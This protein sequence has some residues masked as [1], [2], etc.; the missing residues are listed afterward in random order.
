M[1][2][3]RA[4]LYERVS[5][6]EQA[7]HGYSIK[8]QIDALEEYCEKNQMKIVDHYTDDGVSGGKPAFKRPQMSRLLEDIK[9][10]KIDIVLFTKI[11]RWF[12]NTPEYFKT[13][14]ILEQHG[15]QWKAIWE[16]Y[17]TTS[18]NGRLSVSVFL[19]ISQ[20]ER[21][22]T[23]ERITAVL[24]NK[25]KNREACFGGPNLPFGYMK[26]KDADGIM[27]LVKDPETQEA[28]QDFWNVLL[29]SN[30][31]NKAIRHM[32]NVYGIK[33]DWK[34]W[35]RISHNDFYCG[36]HKG[37]VDYCDPY[38]S[39]EDFLKFQE[40]ETVKHTPS[41]SVYFFRGMMQCPECG[42]RLCGSTNKK[43][44]GTYKEYRCRARG[45]GCDNHSSVPEKKVE[46]Q[47]LTRLAEFLEDEIAKVELEQAKPKPKPK[48]NVK[49]LKERQRRLTV[50]YMAGNIPDEEYLKED[51]EL[52]AL[53]AKAEATAPPEQRDITPLKE[54]LET[55]FLSLYET[56]NDEEKQR[57]WQQL[58]K[59]IKIENKNVT[60]VIFF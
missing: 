57:F 27:R 44:Y 1:V 26:Q 37:I 3:L 53:I 46:K 30:S 12:R 13:Q 45:R 38:V 25:R 40:R 20:H 42:S 31:L 34:S 21:E 52:K 2:I 18:A 55:D 58:I 43:T 35:K 9:A 8:T 10:G 32:I 49:S 4:G 51:A 22:R 11:D 6:D 7:K 23:A 41:G 17:D 29:K 39:P 59:E 24:E 15:V 16:D 33:K 48:N 47:L 56:L 54:L 36:V 60:E 5:T 19:S 14:E 28:C 50:A